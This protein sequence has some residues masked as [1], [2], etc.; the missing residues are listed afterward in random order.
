MK[1]YQLFIFQ[2]FYSQAT[3]QINSV[4]VHN[5]STEY[6]SD[7]YKQG[8]HFDKI[9]EFMQSNLNSDLDENPLMQLFT[10]LVDRYG[11]GK[12]SQFGSMRLDPGKFNLSAVALESFGKNFEPEM[13]KFFNRCGSLLQTQ[14]RWWRSG[15]L[16]D[17]LSQRLVQSQSEFLQN[18]CPWPYICSK[19]HT[20]T[21]NSNI[22]WCDFLTG[23]ILA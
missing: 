9:M 2:V 18:I 16:Y 14:A 10:S 7:N 1:L 23:S 4:V 15:L 5:P 11:K 6:H 22:I 13:L 20:F 21:K 12:P 8:F 3:Y 17:K 19:L